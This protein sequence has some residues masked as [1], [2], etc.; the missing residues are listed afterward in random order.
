MFAQHA[1]A[2][3]IDGVNRRVVHGLRRQGQPIGR[4]FTQ[5][6]LR[7]FVFELQQKCVVCFGNAPKNL[8]CLSQTGAYAVRQFAGSSA[9]EGHHQHIL[10][11]H[12]PHRCS[13]L[14]A[15]AQDQAHIQGCNGP[16]FASAC[17]G[18][19]QMAAAQR[20][21]VDVQSVGGHAFSPSSLA[22][23]SGKG[24]TCACAAQALS[25]AYTASDRRPKA[26]VSSKSARLG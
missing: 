2:P 13:A 8:R 19:D 24:S 12:G 1:L 17:T 23:A 11:Q 20:K 10:R 6:T 14:N 15:V 4:L 5:F 9:G 26:C 21:A 16:G 25:G 18:L 22:R 3:G 7:K